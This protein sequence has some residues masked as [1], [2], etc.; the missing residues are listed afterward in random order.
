MPRQ[1][2]ELTNDSKHVGVRLTK[3]QYEEWKRLGGA[4]WLR[5]TLARSLEKK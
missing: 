5:L 2:S 4:K 3:S 1:K